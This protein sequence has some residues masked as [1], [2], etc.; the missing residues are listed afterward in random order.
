VKNLNSGRKKRRNHT[1]E[2]AKKFL[3]ECEN[4]LASG[5]DAEREQLRLERPL[6]RLI[7]NDE[8][9]YPAEDRDR[10]SRIVDLFA[11]GPPEPR[12]QSK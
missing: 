5:T 10:A 1:P 4:I 11:L 12:G 9:F 8:E 2:E 3:A 6:L 7:V